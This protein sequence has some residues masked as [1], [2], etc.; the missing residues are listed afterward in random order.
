MKF[1]MYSDAYAWRALGSSLKMSTDIYHTETSRT[2]P[3]VDGQL[4]SCTW[5][6]K[7]VPIIVWELIGQQHVRVA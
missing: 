5:G 2:A 3:C 1:L 7:G 6:S 4:I